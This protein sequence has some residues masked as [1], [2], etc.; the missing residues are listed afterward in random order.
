MNKK[1]GY[2][3]FGAIVVSVFAPV[4]L[5]RNESAGTGANVIP[6]GVD[7]RAVTGVSVQN[8]SQAKTMNQGEDSQLMIRTTEQEE[9]G[10]GAVSVPLRSE[11]ALEKMSEVSK[12]VEE[13]LETK[14]LRGGIGDQVRLV[15]QDQKNTQSQI[16]MQVEKIDNR[17][18]FLKSLIGPNFGAIKSLEKQME[19]NQLRI[20]QLTELKNQL[21]NVGDVAMV[22]E[23][24]EAITAQNMALSE[25]INAETQTGSVF[26]WLFRLFAR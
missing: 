21:V 1:I 23:T 20:E 24:I 18:R 9:L 13:L 16:I 12:S 4:C 19:Q 17:G 11:K 3:V 26:G 25:T 22:Q 10:M 14:T 5:A 2:F 15:A 8:K 6:E 7:V